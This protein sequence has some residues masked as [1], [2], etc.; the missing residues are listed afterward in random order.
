MYHLHAPIVVPAGMVQ[1]AHIGFALSLK[2]LLISSQT[3]LFQLASHQDIP[4]L[5]WEWAPVS[6]A[7]VHS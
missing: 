2:L 4:Q 1:A 7:S 6:Q 5:A 3:V